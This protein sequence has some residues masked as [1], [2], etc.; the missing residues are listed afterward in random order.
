MDKKDKKGHCLIT[1]AHSFC[2][3]CY[4][5]GEKAGYEKGKQEIIET[6]E[7]IIKDKMK[8]LPKPKDVLKPTD[9]DYYYAALDDSLV[10]LQVEI[11]SLKKKAGVA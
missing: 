6:V 11:E 9:K 4:E 1:L 7:N 8:Q 3:S 10:D 2:P 5:Q